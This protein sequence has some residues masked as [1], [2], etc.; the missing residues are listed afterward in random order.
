MTLLNGLRNSYF[1][2]C[3]IRIGRLL[4]TQGLRGECKG[5]QRDEE[6]RETGKE[7]GIGVKRE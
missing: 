4:D 3:F 6:E 7:G 1:I 2:I 5:G